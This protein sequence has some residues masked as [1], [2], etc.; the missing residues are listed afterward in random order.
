MSWLWQ[1]VI[2]LSSLA[3]FTLLVMHDHPYA[4]IVP[5]LGFL[6]YQVKP[7]KKSSK[8]DV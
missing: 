4:A 2:D 5:A 8:E 6:T 7:L 1:I 3:A